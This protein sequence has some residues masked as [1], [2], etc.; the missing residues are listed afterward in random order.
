[1]QK[2]GQVEFKAEILAVHCQTTTKSKHCPKSGCNHFRLE[3]YLLLHL[4]IEAETEAAAK[5][6]A[7]AEATADAET[8]ATHELTPKQWHH[9]QRRTKKYVAR[10]ATKINHVFVWTFYHDLESPEASRRFLRAILQKKSN[11]IPFREANYL[12]FGTIISCILAPKSDLCAFRWCLF[13]CLFLASFLGGL[14]HTF[15]KIWCHF[16]IHPFVIL[17]ILW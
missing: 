3:L 15:C 10:N 9:K 14:W 2:A 8:R 7:E 12:R 6:E 1:M 5:T 16:G 13:L 17:R 4:S 11:E